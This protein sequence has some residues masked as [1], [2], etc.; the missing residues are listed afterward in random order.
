M[1]QVDKYYTVIDTINS[2]PARK[3][4]YGKEIKRIGDLVTLQF[5]NGS[6]ADFHIDRVEEAT[7]HGRR[8]GYQPPQQIPKT[9]VE[10]LPKL[11]KSKNSAVAES[12]LLRMAELADEVLDN[13]Y[14]YIKMLKHLLD[15][16]DKPSLALKYAISLMEIRKLVNDCTDENPSN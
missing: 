9:W 2:V 1:E 11:L 14:A 8:V 3:K 16:I 12:Q 7:K 15:I 13:R 4:K 5:E 10:I 6:V